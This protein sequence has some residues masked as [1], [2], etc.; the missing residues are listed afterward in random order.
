M[1]GW[2]ETALLWIP[3]FYGLISQLMPYEATYYRRS[4]DPTNCADL[5][6][7]S[8]LSIDDLIALRPRLGTTCDVPAV[9]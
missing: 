9:H 7:D 3:D 6:G 5:T 1:N 8:W 4:T 2:F